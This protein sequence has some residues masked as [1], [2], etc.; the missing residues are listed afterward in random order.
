MFAN[1]MVVFVVLLTMF[2][3]PMTGPAVRAHD[4]LSIVR[5][6]ADAM[7]EHGRDVYGP[8]HSP[9]FAETLDRNTMR[10]LEGPALDDVAKIPYEQWGIRPHD[11][12][13][14]G[15][16]PQHCQNLYQILYALATITGREHYAQEADRSLAFFFEHCQSPATGLL[17]WGEHAGW[18]LHREGPLQTRSGDIHEFYRPWVLWQRSW[19]LAPQA[20]RRFALGLWE[21]QIGDHQTGD[22]SRHARISAHGPDTE[23]PYARHGGFYIETWAAAYEQTG[24]QVFLQA[25]E[26]VLD[27]LER[28]RLD[29]GGYLTARTRATGSR[30]PFAVSLAISLENAAAAV[31]DPLAAKM[32]AVAQANDEAFVKTRAPS[33]APAPATGQNLWTNAYGSGARVGYA[34][35]LMLRYRQTQIE[36]YRDTI[37]QQARRYRDEEINMTHA[38]WPG[39]VGQAVLLMLNAHELSG[40]AE[41]LEAADRFAHQ[42]IELF[43]GDGSPL[44]KASH[45][46]N[47]YEAVTNGDTLM[48]ALLRLWQVKNRPDIELS[49]IDSDR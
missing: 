34:N 8:V 40:E 11:R 41:F 47:H 1:R 45:L 4:L 46:H 43:L 15:A 24:E 10:M 14:G 23:A 13:L 12:M 25:I 9:L 2:L 17:Y 39:T 16:N 35:G 22:F 44:P 18:D 32:R 36:A 29:E 33:S 48:M 26:T 19:T 37:L 27:G 28:A 38:V 3:T 20:C 49:L 5:D 21:H 31:P 42:A 30:A 7:I 6:Y